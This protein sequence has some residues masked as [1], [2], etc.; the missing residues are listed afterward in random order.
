VLLR[1][2]GEERKKKKKTS[3][4][5][6]GITGKCLPKKG[7]ETIVHKIHRDGRKKL[8]SFVSCKGGRRG[9]RK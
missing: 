5:Q 2:T 8:T 1:R 6:K 3:D 7:K 4:V 9:R